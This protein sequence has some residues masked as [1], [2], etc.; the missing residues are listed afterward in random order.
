MTYNELCT[1]G[2]RLNQMTRW[3]A[4]QS[5]MAEQAREWGFDI[6]DAWAMAEVAEALQADAQEQAARS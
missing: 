1:W 5:E 4:T 3:H 6:S 2:Y